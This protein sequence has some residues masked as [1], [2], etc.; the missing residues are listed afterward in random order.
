MSNLG[1]FTYK[2]F[3]TLRASVRSLSS[4]RSH[5]NFKAVFLGETLSALCAG[6]RFL[7]GVNSHVDFKGW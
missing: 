7:S 4:V 1:L 6:V 3:T 2:A 5:V